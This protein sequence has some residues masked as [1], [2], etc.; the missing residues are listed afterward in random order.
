MSEPRACCRARDEK[1]K[2]AELRSMKT[3]G[4]FPAVS[5]TALCLRVVFCPSL[6]HRTVSEG[7]VLSQSLSPHCV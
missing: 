7:G 2:A 3:T 6:C 5:V 4:S 1:Q